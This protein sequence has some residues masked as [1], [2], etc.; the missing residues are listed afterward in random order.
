MKV[1]SVREDKAKICLLHRE[2][3]KYIETQLK[4]S[5]TQAYMDKNEKFRETLL[6]V[7]NIKEDLHK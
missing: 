4:T 7:K 6:L 2:V 1:E 5:K 3:S